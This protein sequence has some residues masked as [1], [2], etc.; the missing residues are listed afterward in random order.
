MSERVNEPACNC[1]KE[2]KKGQEKKKRRGTIAPSLGKKKYYLNQ[3]FTRVQPDG[4]PLVLLGHAVVLG[5]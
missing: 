5:V 1:R 2:T 4:I 3:R